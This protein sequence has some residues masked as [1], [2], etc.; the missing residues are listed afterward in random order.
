MVRLIR[1]G[2]H[3]DFYLSLYFIIYFKPRIFKTYYFTSVHWFTNFCNTLV[4]PSFIMHLPDDGQKSGRNMKEEH[5]VYNIRY[6]CTLNE[7]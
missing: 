3:K 1:T 7:L 2:K 4:Y 6:L 5:C